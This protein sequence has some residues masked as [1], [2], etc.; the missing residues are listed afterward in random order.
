MDLSSF[1]EKTLNG[2]IY[3][4]MVALWVMPQLLQDKPNVFQH[5]GAP[6]DIHNEVTTFLNRQLAEGWI[7]RGGVGP[8][9]G[10]RY[11]QI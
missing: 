9:S 8:L 6:L 1:G 3:H 7:G 4:E 10:L 2:I 11:L 5:D